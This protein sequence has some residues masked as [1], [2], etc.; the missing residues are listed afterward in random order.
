MY[1][2]SVCPYQ[3][4]SALWFQ[5]E[6]TH[7]SS[8]VLQAIAW[9]SCQNN[10]Y[11]ACISHKSE[12]LTTW[13]TNGTIGIPLSM[14]VLNAPFL[15]GNMSG[16]GRRLL[17]PSGIIIKAI[18]SFL[19]VSATWFIVSMAFSWFCRFNGKHARLNHEPKM[20]IF[21]NSFLPTAVIPGDAM[22]VNATTSIESWWLAIK[23]QGRVAVKY[24][25]PSTLKEIPVANRRNGYNIIAE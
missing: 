15:N 25:F 10:P 17:V 12:K 6:V 8:I 2:P 19:R 20:G 18:L 16:V 22:A 11:T 21:A 7:E 23:M 4:L 13:M 1:P 14:A 9:L 3:I 5:S 24:C